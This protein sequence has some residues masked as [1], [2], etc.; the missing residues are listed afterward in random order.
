SNRAGVARPALIRNQY[1]GTI[2]GPIKKNKLFFFYNFEGRKDRSQSAKT[3]LVP[4]AT[5]REG[6]VQV[7]LKS[8]A[9]VAL[10]P[11]QV[12]AI[13]PLGIGENPYMFNLMQ[14]YPQGNDPS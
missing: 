7:L 14:Q 3:D 13:D 11:A 5:F 4:S 12:K 1:G 8:G 9:T 2:G 10:T 6:I